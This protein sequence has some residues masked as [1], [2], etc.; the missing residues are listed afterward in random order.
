MVRGTRDN[1]TLE[2]ADA[3]VEGHV[4]SEDRGVSKFSQ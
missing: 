3:R 2:R 1:R 4:L